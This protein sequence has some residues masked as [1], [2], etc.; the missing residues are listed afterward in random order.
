MRHILSHVERCFEIFLVL[1]KSLLKYIADI[2]LL[3]KVENEERVFKSVVSVNG[4]KY[5][6]TSG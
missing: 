6:S 5:T 3:L 4:E 2:S 1:R